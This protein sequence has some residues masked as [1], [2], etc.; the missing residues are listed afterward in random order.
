MTNP[1]P[2]TCHLTLYAPTPNHLYVAFRG[3][4]DLNKGIIYGYGPTRTAATLDLWNEEFQYDMEPH[5]EP[6]QESKQCTS[7][8]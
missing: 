6:Q 5:M 3:D 4:P 2:I 7:S 8:S 1:L